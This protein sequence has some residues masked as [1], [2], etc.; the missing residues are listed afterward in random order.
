MMIPIFGVRDVRSAAEFYRDQLGFFLDPQNGIYVPFGEEAVY[1]ILSREG[2]EIHFQ[3]RR[4]DFPRV[5]KG[6]LDRDAYAFVM[7]V[8]EL[9]A[10]YRT[11][12]ITI[13]QELSDAPYGLREFT[14]EDP[15]GF[16][17]SFGSALPT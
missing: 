10:E 15:F 6:K 14:I 17:I 4:N 16:S 12:N 13:V 9:W 3:I 8:E 7:N 1:A 5:K 11:R 2:L